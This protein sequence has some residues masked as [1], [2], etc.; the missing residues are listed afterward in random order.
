M[1]SSGLS[2]VSRL[3]LPAA[4]RDTVANSMMR[5]SALCLFLAL[6][7]SVSAEVDWEKVAREAQWEWPRPDPTV[8]TA[9]MDDVEDSPYDVVIHRY[10]WKVVW[11][12]R[13]KNLDTFGC[14]YDLKI[15]RN[16]E[17]LFQKPAHDG[18]VFRILG[19]RIFFAQ[20]KPLD[21]GCK[22]I[23]FDLDAKKLL[24][25]TELKAVGFVGHSAYHNRVS[26]GTSDKVVRVYG[27]ETNGKYV[28]YLDPNTG[29]RL[30]HRVFE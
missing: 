14:F 8:L 9:T 1:R 24:W 11:D 6:A 10:P 23:C 12:E 18:T 16:G 28:E 29:K 3:L 30:A 17:V 15:M 21:C 13:N 5:I 2:R 27:W 26:L 19:N 4:H 7:G 25:E 22:I 20:F